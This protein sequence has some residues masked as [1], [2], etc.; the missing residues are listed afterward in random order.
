MTSTPDSKAAP[1]EIPEGPEIPNGSDSPD[2]LATRAPGDSD[3][4]STEGEIDGGAPEDRASEEAA[5]ADDEAGDDQAEPAPDDR[6]D[7]VPLFAIGPW[8]WGTLAA[9]LGAQLLLTGLPL[10]FFYQPT[11]QGAA[12]SLVELKETS[13]FGFLRDLHLWASHGLLIAGWLH[14]L[15][16]FALGSYRRTVGWSATVGLGIVAV[17]AA[18]TG[19]RLPSPA[20]EAPVLTIWVIHC[21]ILP[22][23]AAAIVGLWIR[24]RRARA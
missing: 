21:V 16:V 18:W 3:A 4:E 8:L 23:V 22:L 24:A 17:L 14:L 6:P 13:G 7:T 1:G 9:C 19:S 2:A 10:L 12:L 11:P 20:P 5:A 15:R